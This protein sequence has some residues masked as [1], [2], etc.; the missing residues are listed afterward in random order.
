MP[1]KFVPNSHIIRRCF[2]INIENFDAKLAL[3]Q[4]CPIAAATAAG[5][6]ERSS[7]F[8]SFFRAMT[9]G[10]VVSWRPGATDCNCTIVPGAARGRRARRRR[11]SGRG[12]AT[13]GARRRAPTAAG[14]ASP[15]RRRSGTTRSRRRGCRRAARA[16][17]RDDSRRGSN[18]NHTIDR[19]HT[20][21]RVMDVKR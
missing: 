8:L 13:R 18:D 4:I 2:Y 19:A 16:A 11:R 3:M 17:P 5:G 1:T 12:T 6:G 15:A 9:A 20:K 21:R 14:R 7:F 10:W